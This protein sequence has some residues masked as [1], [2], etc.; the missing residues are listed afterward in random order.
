MIFNPINKN[1]LKNKNKKS[2]AKIKFWNGIEYPPPI[3]FHQTIPARQA[4]HLCA[5]CV[6][7]G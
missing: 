2:H 1:A 6:P 7:L 4:S 3:L 5:V